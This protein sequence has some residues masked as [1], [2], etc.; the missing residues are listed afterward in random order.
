MVTTTQVDPRFTVVGAGFRHH[1]PRAHKPTWRQRL[2][3]KPILSLMMLALVA[4]CC[5]CAPF[6]ANHDPAGFYLD[7]RNQAPNGVFYF[8]TDS[9]GR[10]LFSGLFY[11]GRTSLTV[12]LLGAAVIAVIGTVYGC[13]SGIAHDKLDAALMR[14]AELC[15]SVPTLLSILILTACFPAENVVSMAL[16]LGVT[17]WFSLARLVRSEVRQI[18]GCEYILYARCS[19]GSFCYVMVRH[20]I[21]NFLSAILFVLI[22]N[23]GTCITMES[24]LSFLGLGLPLDILS[25]GSM[26]SLA[27]KALL[28]NTWWVIVI[29]GL[30]LVGTLLC[31]TNVGN[32]LRKE[33][34]RRP[35][36]L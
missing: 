3:G 19:G 32:A 5:V 8:G 31:I 12:G 35:T 2:H 20:L 30:F 4:G 29:P 14:T 33:N 22:S 7:A 6:V 36:C 11:G 24:T 10:D 9:L 17:G 1:V 21:P 18:R 26:L 28:L 15:G 25:W 23:I 27:N 13:V 34:T 16:I